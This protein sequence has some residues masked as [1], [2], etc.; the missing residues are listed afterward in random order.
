MLLI[1]AMTTCHFIAQNWLLAHVGE[2]PPMQRTG[3]S[4]QH[5]S[6]SPTV[7]DATAH[8]NPSRVALVNSSGH[9]EAEQTEAG[10]PAKIQPRVAA[11][12]R[13][14]EA[15]AAARAAA[16]KVAAELRAK[17]RE[18]ARHRL[19]LSSAWQRIS[20][21]QRA[22]TST[23]SHAT[24]S[25]AST[26]RGSS[27]RRL[28]NASATDATSSRPSSRR[29]SLI[30][31]LPSAHS[32]IVGSGTLPHAGE[33][34]S[35]RATDNTTVTVATTSLTRLADGSRVVGTLSRGV[36]DII[37]G[38]GEVRGGAIASD[39]RLLSELPSLLTTW[40]STIHH[41]ATRLRLNVSAQSSKV[42]GSRLASSA[43]HEHRPALI[44]CAMLCAQ[45]S[46]IIAAIDLTVTSHGVY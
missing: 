8:T 25:T 4:D 45:C 11:A 23:I 41:H 35:L 17:N 43:T 36:N 27:P 9:A 29:P 13:S 34:A 12:P 26:G 37:S 21:L 22:P 10:R 2:P 42:I 44:L 1:A 5:G 33:N 46:L 7:A 32:P 31:Q 19:N 15:V 40:W 20:A 6:A 18:A 3:A 14:A 39:P 16:A 30:R 28:V 38:D 24:T